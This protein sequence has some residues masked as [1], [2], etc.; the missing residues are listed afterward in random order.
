MDLVGEVKVMKQYPFVMGAQGSVK[1]SLDK[2]VCS[3]G[4]EV[5]WY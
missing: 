3:L 4:R 1:Y 5:N 2:R